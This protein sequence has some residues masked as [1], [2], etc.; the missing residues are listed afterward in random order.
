MTFESLLSWSSL[1]LM[2]W[3]TILAAKPTGILSTGLVGA[4][5]PL[6][7]ETRGIDDPVGNL[8]LRLAGAVIAV[9]FAA[10]VAGPPWRLETGLLPHFATLLSIGMLAAWLIDLPS[11]L[12]VVILAVAFSPLSVFLPASN[13]GAETARASAV[14]FLGALLVVP[15]S[16]QWA[17]R[18]GHGAFSG[19]HFFLGV[20]WGLFSWIA[21]ENLTT[22]LAA[23]VLACSCLA[24]TGTISR[25]RLAAVASSLGVGLAIVWVPIV[26]L[27]VL[28]GEAS[29]SVQNDFRSAALYQVTPLIAIGGSLLVFAQWR[30]VE[31]YALTFPQ[32]RLLA[33]GS[34]LG[35]CALTLL[36]RHDRQ[37]IDTMLAL[38]FVLT[39]TFRD[40]PG[41]LSP[42]LLGRAVARTTI[43][44]VAIS[45]FPIAPLFTN[46]YGG[47]IKPA[48]T[49]FAGRP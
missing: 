1:A 30:R 31:R 32:A 11:A 38:P 5:R 12:L 17:L 36:Y 8:P 35:A 24:V 29:A 21:P 37:P 49:R 48:F 43:V 10:L 40:M 39:L 20:L 34:V 27:R 15:L 4:A 41:W 7:P 42:H 23:A 3:M 16:V 33:F 14:T 6:P 46:L 44:A 47:L 28:S 9:G 25:R 2:V 26:A 45:V 13:A 18:T 19:P 22:T